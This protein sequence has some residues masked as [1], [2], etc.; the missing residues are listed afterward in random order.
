[1]KQGDKK[2]QT[3]SLIL[4][5]NFQNLPIGDTTLLLGNVTDFVAT[6]EGSLKIYSNGN[7]QQLENFVSFYRSADR[8][9]ISRLVEIQA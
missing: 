8:R 7:F 3:I 4:G 9:R 5:T 6:A 2:K 1:L